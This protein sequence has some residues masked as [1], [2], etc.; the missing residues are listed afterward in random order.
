M[1]GNSAIP[2]RAVSA[3]PARQ[4]VRRAALKDLDCLVPFAAALGRGQSQ[5][6][7]S[8][9]AVRALLERTLLEWGSRLIVAELHGQVVG[10]CAYNTGAARLQSLFVRETCRG[11]GL[12][13]ELVAFAEQDLA[14]AGAADVRLAVAPDNT[15]AHAFLARLGYAR[16]SQAGSGDWLKPL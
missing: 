14:R 11:R 6:P 4:V 13:R 8:S 9:P 16:S 3:L 1:L 7:S 15:A 10:F 2:V 5:P 12:G